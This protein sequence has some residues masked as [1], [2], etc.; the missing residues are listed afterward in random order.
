MQPWKPDRYASGRPWILCRQP[1]ATENTT[2][3]KLQQ[4][5][6]ARM[7]WLTTTTTTSSTTTTT[8]P[9]ILWSVAKWARGLTAQCSCSL[10]IQR[11][12]SVSRWVAPGVLSLVA[13]GN[14]WSTINWLWRFALQIENNFINEQT[15][16]LLTILLINPAKAA[17]ANHHNSIGNWKSSISKAAAW[18][19]NLKKTYITCRSLATTLRPWEEQRMPISIRYIHWRWE[20]E[21]IGWR[22]SSQIQTD[23]DASISNRNCQIVRFNW[24]RFVHQKQK[25]IRRWTAKFYFKSVRCL[26]FSAV[27]VHRMKTHNRS[28]IAGR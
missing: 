20:E 28:Y 22:F 7:A 1:P 16:S 21:Q 6:K 14:L 19:Y 4:T 12:P 26:T 5:G 9:S 8:R 15:N 3:R 13:T 24:V 18:L 23:F 17:S 25:S 11:Y 10:P 2:A 27:K